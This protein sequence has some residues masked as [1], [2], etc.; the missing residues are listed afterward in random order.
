MRVSAYV[1]LFCMYACRLELFKMLDDS[2]LGDL[3]NYA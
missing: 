2:L 3:L 1:Y